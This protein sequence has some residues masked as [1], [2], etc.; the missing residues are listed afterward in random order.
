MAK[1]LL[2]SKIRDYA[3]LAAACRRCTPQ[4]SPALRCAVPLMPIV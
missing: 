1:K 4:P 2:D 3:I